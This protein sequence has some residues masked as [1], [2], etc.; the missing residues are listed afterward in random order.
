MSVAAFIFTL[1]VVLLHVAFLYM[2]TIGWTRMARRF[3]YNAEKAEITRPLALNQGAYN[4]GLALVLLWA[5]LSGHTATVIA[6]LVYVVAMAI[7]GALSVSRR[8]FVI[9][10]VPALIALFFTLLA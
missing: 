3:G 8:I 4:G 2:E 10:G 7:V 6:M 5:L 1:I 9:Q